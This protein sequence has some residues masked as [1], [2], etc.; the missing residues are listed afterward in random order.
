MSDIIDDAQSYEAMN[1]QQSLSVQ[2]AIA[3]STPRPVPR[4]HCLNP[5]CDEPF[6]ANEK[7]RIYCGPACATAHDRIINPHN[8]R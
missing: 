3:K 2:Q 7:A 8:K 4:G 6:S 1:L 5:D